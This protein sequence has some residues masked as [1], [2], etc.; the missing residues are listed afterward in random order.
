MGVLS[1]CR[2]EGL[3]ILLEHLAEQPGLRKW[4][5]VRDTLGRRLSA[6]A[7]R[8]LRAWNRADQSISKPMVLWRFRPAFYACM[9]K[10]APLASASFRFC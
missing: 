2:D 4:D 6:L 3:P 5:A 8:R 7:R 10:G 1:R 9:D